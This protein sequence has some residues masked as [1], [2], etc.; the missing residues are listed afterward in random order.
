V[1]ISH[2]NFP[3]H[4]RYE[5]QISVHRAEGKSMNK[6][7]GLIDFLAGGSKFQSYAMVDRQSDRQH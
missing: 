4:V 3:V 7:W 1:K 5:E 6:S 2:S